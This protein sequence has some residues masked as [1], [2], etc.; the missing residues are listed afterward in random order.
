MLGFDA[1]PSFLLHH[2]ACL[3]DEG[4]HQGSL[5]IHPN[6]FLFSETLYSHILK[7]WLAATFFPLPIPANLW[8][9]KPS[10]AYNPTFE[11]S[12]HALQSHWHCWSN[13][14]L[15]EPTLSSIE[16]LLTS[17]DLLTLY[18]PGLTEGALP[19]SA[20]FAPSLFVNPKSLLSLVCSSKT[21][22]S[23]G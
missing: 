4:P 23:S 20:S 10:W 5:L 12:G 7:T 14:H 6:T 3:H 21:S 16:S 15:I 2:A 13:S 1:P 17:P 8:H 19:S 18:F 9:S 11:C 22:V